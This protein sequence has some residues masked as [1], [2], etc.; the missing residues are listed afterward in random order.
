MLLIP[1]VLTN[2]VL[3]GLRFWEYPI[4][5][6]RPEAVLDQVV[7]YDN[8]HN[9]GVRFFSIPFD[10]FLYAF[11]LIGLNVALMEYLTS[12]AEARRA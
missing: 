11:L 6:T 5:N 8:A 10:D 7:W 12:R 4:I 1:F 2:G 9:L 3:T